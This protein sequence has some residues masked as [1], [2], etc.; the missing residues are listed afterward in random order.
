[1]EDN[2]IM[3]ANSVAKIG[4]TQTDMLEGV[5][6]NCGLVIGVLSGHEKKDN[7]LSVGADVVV[8]KITD[9]DSEVYCDFYL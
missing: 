7:L 1:M 3:S 9:L 4:D 5:N 8:N 6:A 2:L